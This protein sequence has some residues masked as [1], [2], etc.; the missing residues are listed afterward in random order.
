VDPT[1]EIHPAI[2]GALVAFAYVGYTYGPVVYNLIQAMRKADETSTQA[3]GGA[4]EMV[5]NGNPSPADAN[6]VVEAYRQYPRD[7]GEV[8]KQGAELQKKFHEK[9][10]PKKETPPYERVPEPKATRCAPGTCCLR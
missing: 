7:I 5:K 9:R 10:T 3:Y 8:V 2:A 1:G 4:A 6:Q